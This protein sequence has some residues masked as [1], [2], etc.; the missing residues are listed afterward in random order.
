[1]TET[2]IAVAITDGVAVLRVQ[3]DVTAAS[4]SAFGDA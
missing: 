4:E 3:G 2:T 1:M